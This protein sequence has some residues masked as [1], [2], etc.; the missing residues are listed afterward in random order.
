MIW[1]DNKKYEGFWKN[2]YFHGQGKLTT[3][4]SKYEGGWYEGKMHGK[5][6]YYWSDGRS[7][8]GDYYLNKK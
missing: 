1:E 8:V 6:S 5:G 7:Y 3:P 4:E 2:G